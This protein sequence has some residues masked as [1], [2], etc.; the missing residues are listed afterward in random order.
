MQRVIKGSKLNIAFGYLIFGTLVY[1]LWMLMFVDY[2]PGGN[3]IMKGLGLFVL[4][5]L[6]Y[7]TPKALALHKS[8]IIIE[9]HKLVIEGTFRFSVSLLDVREFKSRYYKFGESSAHYLGVEMLD[10]DKN[11]FEGISGWYNKHVIGFTPVANLDLFCLPPR[12]VVEILND[13][14][15]KAQQGAQI[16]SRS[17]A[18]PR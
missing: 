16:R 9:D 8:R 2:G 7:F 6:I 14:V 13:A 4:G 5:F 1:V 10:E 17:V 18:G 15:K 12:Q 3:V 11:T